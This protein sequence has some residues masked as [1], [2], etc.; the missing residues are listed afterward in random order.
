VPP[1]IIPHHERLTR[2]SPK[3]R[4]RPSEVSTRRLAQAGPQWII[5]QKSKTYVLLGTFSHCPLRAQGP[6]PTQVNARVWGFVIGL[7]RGGLVVGFVFFFLRLT[8]CKKKAGKKSTTPVY[9]KYLL[10]N[11]V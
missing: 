10:L 6:D 9:C 5:W 7:G 11:A 4:I 1:C 3:H 2:G 8:F